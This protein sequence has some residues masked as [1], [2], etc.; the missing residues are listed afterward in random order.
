MRRTNLHCIDDRG[1][2][3]I[4]SPDE[5]IQVVV[6]IWLAIVCPHGLH[7]RFNT[8]FNFL[9]GRVHFR[10]SHL[11]HRQNLDPGRGT[12]KQTVSPSSRDPFACLKPLYP[13]NPQPQFPLHPHKFPPSLF[14]ACFVDPRSGFDSRPVGSSTSA[15]DASV[16]AFA[17]GLVDPRPV[18]L[19]PVSV[20]ATCFVDSRPAEDEGANPTPRDTACTRRFLH[21]LS[22]KKKE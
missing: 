2:S 13:H 14:T 1:E 9:R 5:L 17:S 15:F 6:E 11:H 8:P 12:R 10:T 3:F 7:Q 18:D 20:A 22:A 16:S 19:R 21:A 4:A